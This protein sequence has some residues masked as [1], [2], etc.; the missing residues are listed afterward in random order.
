[1]G[2]LWPLLRGLTQ[3]RWGKFVIHISF[4]HGQLHICVHISV[5]GL[6]TLGNGLAQKR[7]KKVPTKHDSVFYSSLGYLAIGGW[8]LDRASFALFE[9]ILPACSWS[10]FSFGRYLASSQC[11]QEVITHLTQS[12]VCF[13]FTLSNP[14]CKPQPMGSLMDGNGNPIKIVCFSGYGMSMWIQTYEFH[15]HSWTSSSKIFSTTWNSKP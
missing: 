9:D 8:R 12:L 6:P 11:E 3:K 2:L 7:P 5:V 10:S 13:Q 14:I 1:M 15:A 4:V